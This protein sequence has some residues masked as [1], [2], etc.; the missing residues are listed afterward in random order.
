MRHRVL[1]PGVP[2]SYQFRL[3]DAYYAASFNFVQPAF[4]DL[5]AYCLPGASK[6]CGGLLNGQD[7]VSFR[8]FF[9]V[10]KPL[11]F[12]SQSFYQLP[13]LIG[14]SQY[15]HSKK[16]VVLKTKIQTCPQNWRQ[17]Q[18]GLVVFGPRQGATDECTGSYLLSSIFL[19]P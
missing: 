9:A 6:H 7:N 1:C 14:K 4:P 15:L 18:H 3:Q 2:V 17:G 19:P 5:S 11:Q 8:F 16:V 12:I 10:I 13:V